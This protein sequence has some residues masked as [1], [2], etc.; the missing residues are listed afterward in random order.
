MYITFERIY[1]KEHMEQYNSCW[2]YIN[3]SIILFLGKYLRRHK[4][5]CPT[6]CWCLFYSLFC[7][8]KVTY[9]GFY[10]LVSVVFNQK[11][12][13][14]FKISMNYILRMYVLQTIKSISHI[15]FCLVQLHHFL[16]LL[17]LKIVKITQITVLHDHKIPAFV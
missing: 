17:W 10:L 15:L 1:C 5:S 16:R 2:P 6:K 3:S 13:F 8:S 11:Y 12:I 4:I 9:F 7:K 14:G